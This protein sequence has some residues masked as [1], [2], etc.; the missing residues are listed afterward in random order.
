MRMVGQQGRANELQVPLQGRTG[1]GYYGTSHLWSLHQ[2]FMSCL[3]GFWT[4]SRVE[5]THSQT[6]LPP[7]QGCSFYNSS[8]FGYN[9]RL[10]NA[11]YCMEYGLVSGSGLWF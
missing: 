1:Y 9:A 6:Y 4:P 10:P 8:H 2:D 7:A 3:G 5:K 11:N